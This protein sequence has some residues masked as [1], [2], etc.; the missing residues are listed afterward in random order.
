M[1]SACAAAK[2]DQ[3]L[4]CP[5]TESLETTDCFKGEQMHMRGMNLNLCILRM[6]EG[7]FSLG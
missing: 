1:K 6:L 7:T 2:S 3:D 5:Q 4:R